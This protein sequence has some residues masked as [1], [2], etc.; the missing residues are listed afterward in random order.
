MGVRLGTAKSQVSRGWPPWHW[1]WP[2]RSSHEHRGPVDPGPGRGGRD[3]RRRCGGPARP[4]PRAAG[5]TGVPERAP[6]RISRSAAA[7]RGRVRRHR[8]GRRHVPGDRGRLGPATDP[9]PGGRGPDVRVPPSGTSTSRASR[10][11]SSPA[12]AAEA[13]RRSPRSTTHPA[14]TSS[15]T[16]PAPRCGSGTTTGRSARSRRTGR[17][18][19]GWE[20]VSAVA[21]GSGETPSPHRDELRLGTHG[22]SPYEPWMS[23]STTT[24][25]RCSSTTGPCTTTPGW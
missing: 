21:C 5:R 11:S 6:R 15:R 16:G 22:Y 25:R 17:W 7:G 12:S 13:R 19:T 18:T 8:H 10:T 3:R 20:P 1:P 24:E 14:G 23:P 9:D 2:T 4:H